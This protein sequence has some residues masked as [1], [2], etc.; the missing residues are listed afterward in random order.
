MN[1]HFFKEDLQMANMFMKRCLLSQMTRKIHIKTTVRYHFLPT[2]IAIV[3]GWIASS[4][5]TKYVEVL[6][7]HCLWIWP[8]LGKGLYKCNPVKMRSLRWALT[9]YDGCIYK[10]GKF[11]QRKIA[12]WRGRQRLELW[13]HKLWDAWGY[14]NLERQGRNLS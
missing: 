1:R 4:P 9:Q 12:T 7:P 5:P 3:M 8:Y 11:G 10:R 2:G 6:T 13:Y 14:Q